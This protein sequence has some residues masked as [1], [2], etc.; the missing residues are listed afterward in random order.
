MSGPSEA[1]SP[2]PE[3]GVPGDPSASPSDTPRDEVKTNGASADGQ[4]EV[5]DSSDAPP[6]EPAPPAESAPPA[7]PAPP[8]TVVETNAAAPTPSKKPAPTPAE[9]AA[10]DLLLVQ[11]ARIV[12]LVSLLAGAIALWTQLA[13]HSP[14]LDT[15]LLDN[16]LD[17]PERR[18]SMLLVVVAAVGGGAVV[19]FGGVQWWRRRGRPVAELEQW[20]WFLSPLLMMPLGPVLFRPKVWMGRQDALLPS[21]VLIL[22]V[23]EQLAFRCLTNVPPAARTWWLEAVGQIPARVRKYGPLAVVLA[24]A[25][26]FSAFF[27][28]YTLRWHYKLRTG[29]YDLSINNNLMYG[30]LHGRFLQSPLVFPKEPAKYLANHVK[31]GAYL[32]LPIYALAPRPETLFVI[33]SIFIGFGSVP[34]FLFARR[35]VSEWMAAIVCLAYLAYY[36]LHGASFSEFQAVPVAAFFIFVII[37]AADTYRYRWLIGA[38]VA[39]LLMREDVSVGLAVLGAFFLFSGYRPKIGLVIALVSSAYF[40]LLRFYVMDAAGSWWFPNMYKELWADGEKGFRSVIKTMLT[41]PMFTLSKIIV[42]KK[43]YYVLNLLTP[44]AFLPVRRWYLWAAFLPGAFL[45]LLVTN[46]DPP[47]TYSFHYVMHWAPY[48]FVA[49][50][51]ALEALRQGPLFG[52]ERYRAAAAAMV[53][54][55]LVL[56]YN[57]GAF[58]R[59]EGSFKAG[60]SKIEFSFSEDEWDRYQELLEITSI[61]P[62]DASVAATEKCGPHL[63]SRLDMFTMRQGPQTADWIVASSRELKLSRTRPTLKEALESG[64]FGVVKR[65]DDFA[66]M[67]RGAPTQENQALIDDWE[68]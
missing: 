40:L 4:R 63:S 62:K 23:F 55:S 38:L 44:L 42:E 32:F 68:L 5:Q 54:G 25:A 37:W 60:F 17:E 10:R 64:T 19:A 43:I 41:N 12:A 1:G 65:L 47:I 24:G 21:L 51:V 30:G 58:A 49:S 53:A 28:F 35:H 7:E 22:L 8:A 45:T 6:A 9:K 16:E 57:Y 50:V 11:T 3:S 15:F 29:N 26:F 52:L 18:M 46:Y 36:P 34:L 14:W 67:K 20:A 66:V 2:Q 56:S 48:L 33:Q 39:A 59:R 61:I 31:L 27:I 13:F